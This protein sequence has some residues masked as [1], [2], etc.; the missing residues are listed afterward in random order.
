MKAEFS[1]PFGE[2]FFKAAEELD[3]VIDLANHR[4][5][6]TMFTPDGGRLNGHLS[7]REDGATISATLTEARHG[8]ISALLPILDMYNGRGC[9]DGFSV[10][11][12]P[13]RKGKYPNRVTAMCEF[14]NPQLAAVRDLLRKFYA[15]LDDLD[16][17]LSSAATAALK[18][19]LR[20]AFAVGSDAAE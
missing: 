18:K 19:R 20:E 16:R 7:L 3:L 4:P 15:K 9:H 5:K 6:M 13:A 8:Q 17:V 14:R 11:Y 1:G 10:E 12:I 2:A